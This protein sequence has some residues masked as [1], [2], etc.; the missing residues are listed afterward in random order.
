MNNKTK[1]VIT[2]FVIAFGI[3][4]HAQGQIVYSTTQPEKVDTSFIKSFENDEQRTGLTP[5]TL[6]LSKNI[7]TRGN[8][9]T[10]DMLKYNG[11]E[12]EYGDFNVIEISVGTPKRF[13]AL[14][15]TS[16]NKRKVF[17]LKNDNGW[18]YFYTENNL[19][20]NAEEPFKVIPLNEACKALVF[21]GMALSNEP[22]FLTVVVISD[23]TAPRLVYNVQAAILDIKSE[24]SETSFTLQMNTVEYDRNNIPYNT[25]I[26]KTLTF[27]NG[28]ITFK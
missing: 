14:S 25:P 4:N 6:K 28:E 15:T 21:T 2:S 17:T 18:D 26:I 5:Y 13:N 12:G 19:N 22:P 16:N 27:G 8:T 11:W 9:F 1:R 10:I 24:G 7:Y 23:N 20:G 3:L